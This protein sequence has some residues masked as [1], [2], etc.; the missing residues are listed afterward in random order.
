M[1]RLVILTVEI[2]GADGGSGH[3]TWQMWTN[4][5]IC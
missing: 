3:V 1:K 2:A 4:A 5:S